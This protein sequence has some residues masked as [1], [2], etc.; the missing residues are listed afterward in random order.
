VLLAVANENDGVPTLI[1]VLLFSVPT[2]IVVLLFSAPPI[3]RLLPPS[4]IPVSRLSFPL[5]L[6]PPSI[7]SVAESCKTAV[8]LLVT[9]PVSVAKPG[10]RRPGAVDRYGPDCNRG[11]QRRVALRYGDV[12]GVAADIVGI[13][14]VAVRPIGDGR[15]IG[16]G[17]VP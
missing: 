11:S 10:P 13:G 17:I 6:N 4:S 2:L 15:P 7:P 14:A 1:V 8:P 9:P 5:L 16:R 3:V 12:V